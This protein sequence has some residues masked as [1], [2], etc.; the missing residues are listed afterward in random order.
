MYF[1]GHIFANSLAKVFSQA[2]L[3]MKS[4]RSWSTCSKHHH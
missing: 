3:I 2:G 1:N 4:T